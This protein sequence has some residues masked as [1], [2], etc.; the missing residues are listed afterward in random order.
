[1]T[2][3]RNTRTHANAIHGLS[4]VEG[5]ALSNTMPYYAVWTLPLACHAAPMRAYDICLG[6]VANSEDNMYT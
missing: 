5:V 1:M 2:R 6:T 3:G 4:L